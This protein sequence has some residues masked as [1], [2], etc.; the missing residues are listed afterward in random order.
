MY[1]GLGKLRRHISVSHYCA[2]EDQT[3]NLIFKKLFKKAHK[4]SFWVSCGHIQEQSMKWKCRSNLNSN[5]DFSATYRSLSLCRKCNKHALS[6]RNNGEKDILKRMKR[7]WE[8]TDMVRG[9]S[10]QNER[11]NFLIYGIWWRMLGQS[12]K[13]GKPICCY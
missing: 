6:L 10:V 3:F 13:Q 9:K 4:A 7:E 11:K 2:S 5:W 8:W 12:I 1:F